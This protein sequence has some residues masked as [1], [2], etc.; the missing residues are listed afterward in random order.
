MKYC[1]EISDHRRLK[2]ITAKW[3]THGK[4]LQAV[5]LWGKLETPPSLRP[6]SIY[7][8]FRSKTSLITIIR[9]DPHSAQQINCQKILFSHTPRGTDTSFF[10]LIRFLNFSF[11]VT[12]YYFVIINFYQNYVIIILFNFFF[13][14]IIFIFSYSGMFRVP[15]F[16]RRPLSTALGLVSRL[17]R[18]CLL[19]P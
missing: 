19:P 11:S 7:F 2:W 1:T 17:F 12:S 13:M 5:A 15:G 8:E 9:M 14:K 6:I 18:S 4:Q 3:L 10:F 16:Y